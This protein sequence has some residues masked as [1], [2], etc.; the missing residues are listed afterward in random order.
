[1]NFDVVDLKDKCI[2]CALDC[3]T[4]VDRDLSG[5][6]VVHYPEPNEGTYGEMVWNVAQDGTITA[7]YLS[8]L[9]PGQSNTVYTGT[10]TRTG[11]RNTFTVTGLHPT[12]EFGNVPSETVVISDDGKTLSVTGACDGDATG[13]S[14]NTPGICCD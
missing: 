11:A 14:S 13:C 7:H 4:L 5:T 12:D 10:A 1:M 9:L 6:W 8:G 2:W 3:D